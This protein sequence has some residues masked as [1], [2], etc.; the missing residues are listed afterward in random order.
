ME[1]NLMPTGTNPQGALATE[2]I[3]EGRF[4]LMT[5]HTW[6]EDFGSLTDLPG[7]KLPDNDTEAQMARYVVTWSAPDRKVSPGNLWFVPTP[8]YDF[9][10]RHGWDQ[11]TN[12]PMSNVTVR[13]IWP[14][15]QESVTIPS[16]TKVLVLQDGAIVTLPSGQY[17]YNSALRTPG[18]R[19]EVLNSG[20]DGADSAGKPAYAAAGAIAEVVR[21]NSSTAAL[22][23][24]LLG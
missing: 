18:A 1:I 10:L 11:D 3:V 2:D 4:V 17:V 6:D 21:F 19:L 14:G 12:L 9:A 20:D 22:T 24:R 15:N 7:V 8:A 16:G 13:D 23:I 5:S